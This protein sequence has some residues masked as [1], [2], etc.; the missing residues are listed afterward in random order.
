MANIEQHFNQRAQPDFYIKT[1]G[2]TLEAHCDVLCVKSRWFAQQYRER[3]EPSKVKTALAKNPFKRTATPSSTPK[4][5]DCSDNPILPFQAFFNWCYTGTYT[6]PENDDTRFIFDREVYQIALRFDVPDLM[7]LSFE[8]FQSS[9][10]APNAWTDQSFRNLLFTQWQGEAASTE[11]KALKALSAQLVKIHIDD[12]LAVGS[13]RRL[14]DVYKALPTLQDFIGDTASKGSSGRS[15]NPFWSR[16]DPSARSSR[17]SGY[18][19]SGKDSTQ[20][21]ATEGRGF[22]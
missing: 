3:F 21:G 7:T 10:A 5:I 9:L 2:K 14:K 22:L 4:V 1:I 13:A 16:S 12:P 11:P 20:G 15:G 17:Q 6:Y 19:G 18:A 8:R